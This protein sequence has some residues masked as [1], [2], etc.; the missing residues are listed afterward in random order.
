[1]Q[2]W[3]S[4]V[5]LLKKCKVSIMDKL[6]E[7]L[8][9]SVEDAEKIVNMMERNG[10]IEFQAPKV[11][12]MPATKLKRNKDTLTSELSMS[13]YKPGNIIINAHADWGQ[14]VISIL[15]LCEFIGS[16]STMSPFLIVTSLLIHIISTYNSAEIKLDEKA[17]AII[18]ALQGLSVHSAYIAT[19]QK[20]MEEANRILTENDFEPM[21]EEKFKSKIKQLIQCKCI[22]WHEGYLILLE[23]VSLSY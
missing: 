16:V 11:T 19:E 1:M 23:K 6:S 7:Y 5:E 20:C 2:L 14:A 8:K 12:Q 13:S 9:I 3:E 22:D 10:I 4:D 18:M 21:S 15:T 17:T